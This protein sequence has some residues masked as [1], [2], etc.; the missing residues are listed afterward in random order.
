VIS[1]VM[2]MRNAEPFV[3]AAVG[4]ILQERR[5]PFELIVVDDGSTDRSRNVVESI[6]DSRLDV[7][8]GPQRGIAASFNT[9]ARLA[10]GDIVMTCD[11]DDLFM[12]GR[13]WAQYQWLSDHP[14]LDAVCGRFD[15]VDS[16]GLVVATLF[17]EPRYSLVADIS[18][19]L[20]SGV[21]RTH[22]CTFAWR[23][24]VFERIGYQ[25][26]YFETGQDLDFQLRMGEQCKVAYLPIDAYRYRLHEASITHV[27][28]D[29]KRKF[30]EV[31][32]H[33]FQ[34]ER[35]SRGA[36]SLSEG[37][38]PVPPTSDQRGSMSV[39]AQI[40]GMLVGRAWQ[41]FDNADLLESVKTA[42]RAASAAP[43]RATGWLQLA[44]LIY[45]G[46]KQVLFGLAARR[47][48]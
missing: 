35:Q 27:Q 36:D 20:A 19:E 4:S 30:F 37:R 12:P 33:S 43:L 2:P 21:L 34:T 39:T 47:D 25:R 23:R 24:S 40:Q 17:Q 16:K 42:C 3:G 32:A 22:L 13:M 5:I 9:G 10:R 29:A 45:K 14:E 8:E 28:S 46:G 44:K 38:A 6:G 31:T 7:V 18:R 26:E 48:G 41:Q 11:A 15:T 1:V